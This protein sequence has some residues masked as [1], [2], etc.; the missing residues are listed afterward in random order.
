MDEA[1]HRAEIFADQ[2]TAEGRRDR[3]SMQDSLGDEPGVAT[4]MGRSCVGG[5]EDVSGTKEGA[6]VVSGRR[7]YR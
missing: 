5:R 3:G 2:I 4:A 1:V 7:H 6:M